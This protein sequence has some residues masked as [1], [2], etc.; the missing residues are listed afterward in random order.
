[1]SDDGMGE[2]RREPP[3]GFQNVDWTRGFGRQVGPRR[4]GLSG[5]DERVTH[6]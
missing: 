1:M 5:T 2:T 6:G 4:E 3:P